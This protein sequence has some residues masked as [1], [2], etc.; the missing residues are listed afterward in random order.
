MN[1]VTLS[2]VALAA[3][4]APVQI[5]AAGLTDEQK[6]ANEASYAKISQAISDAIVY[7]TNNCP[8]VK[9]GFLTELSK[10][11]AE[12]NKIDR[13]TTLINEKDFLARVDEQK[14]GAGAA[15]QPHTLK[16]ILVSK[17]NLLKEYRDAVK[18][19]IDGLTYTGKDKATKLEAV[20]V[21]ALVNRVDD[22]DL[23]DIN[24]CQATSEAITK[25]IEAANEAIKDIE[26]N[27]V[28]D[29]E[30]AAKEAKLQ[31]D[32]LAAK[33]AV[34]DAVA[35]ARTKYNTQVKNTISL[36]PTEPYGDWQAKALEELNAQNRIL[37]E[38]TAEVDVQ[39]DERQNVI[40]KK[41]ANLE[42]VSAVNAEI[43]KIYNNW[44][45]KKS[46]QEEAYKTKTASAA[47]FQTDLNTVVGK[48]AA[49]E[50]AELN[51]DI[52]AIQNK[53]NTLNADIEKAYKGH[54]IN[55][56]TV[57]AIGDDITALDEKAQPLISNYNAYQGHLSAIATVKGTFN[58]AKN[59]AKKASK[60]KK[61]KAYDYLTGY[62]EGIQQDID[63]LTTAAEA[64][65]K[66]KTSSSHTV[67][68]TAVDTKIANYNDWATNS[69]KSYNKA[70]DNIAK[71][72]KQLNELTAL[73]PEADRNVTVDGTTKGQ[74]YKA[75]FEKLQGEIKAINDAI[76]AAKAKTG[77]N[78]KKAMATAASKTYTTVEDGVK[79][80]TD[81]KTNFENATRI[82]A[83]TLMV[84]Q[85]ADLVTAL[86]KR[87]EKANTGDNLGNQKKVIEDQISALTTEIE[88]ANKV[89]TDAGT[90]TAENAAQIIADLSTVNKN[91]LDLEEKVEEVE[92]AAADARVNHSLYTAVIEKINKVTEKYEDLNV[93]LTREA[94]CY[95]QQM[96]EYA[97]TL[98]EAKTNADNAYAQVKMA[99]LSESINIALDN[100]STELDALP[101][102]ISANNTA[103]DKQI[104]ACEALQTLWDT[105][106]DK[107]SNYDLSSDATK[108]LNRLAVEQQNI[109]KLS[110]DIW[111][112]WNEGN[113]VAK[114]SEF[115]S[116]NS[117]IEKAIKAI[118]N[119]Q[120]EGYNAAIEAD[121][122]KQHELFTNGTDGT[123][124]IAYAEFSNAIAKL[125][126]FSS[127]KNDALKTAVD[128]LVDTHKAIYAYAEKL[129]N[130]AAEESEAYGKVTSP[131]RYFSKVYSDQAN[132]YK[133]EIAKLLLDYQTK[134]NAE[135][136]KIYEE[137]WTT[138]DAAVY[139][140]KDA[141]DAYEYPEKAN[142]FKDIDDVLKEIQTALDKNDA[143]FALKLDTWLETIALDAL[144]EQLA[145]DKEK[146][147]DAEYTY[148]VLKAS[149]VYQADKAAI[150]ALGADY[151]RYVDQLVARAEKTIDAAG[152]LYT[153]SGD[154]TFD[155]L[156]KILSKLNGFYGTAEKDHTDI[157]NTALAAKSDA[158]ANQ[159]AYDKLIKKLDLVEADFGDLAANIEKLLVFYQK[160]TVYKAA[161]D[162]DAMLE[163]MRG[164]VEEW[165]GNRLCDDNEADVN[166]FF[167]ND[168]EKGY[169]KQI[170]D[171][172]YLTVA[173]EATALKAEVDK[174][175]DLFNQ[176]AAQDLDKVKEYEKNINALSTAIDA[177]PT[178]YNESREDIF[179]GCVDRYLEIEKEIAEYGKALDE[180]ANYGAYAAAKAEVEAALPAVEALVAEAQEKAAYDEAIAA[181]YGDDAA[182]V[183]ESLEE[184]KATIAAADEAGQLL[185]VKDNLINRIGI[186]EETVN[187]F[188]PQLSTV[189]NKHVTSN[190]VYNSLSAQI[191]S[192]ESWFNEV[193]GNIAEYEYAA[194]YKMYGR[195]ANG[196]WV[197][198]S[199]VD[200]YNTN[201]AAEIEL[202]K[203]DLEAAKANF[204]LIYTTAEGTVNTRVANL[205]GTIDN[206][207]K[208]VTVNEAQ[209]GIN[210]V[211]NTNY[212]AWNV[213]RSGKY[214]PTTAAAIQAEYSRI[215]AAVNAARTYN[216]NVSQ[217]GSASKD[218]YGND[219]SYNGEPIHQNYISEAWPAVKAW[220]AEFSKD[221]EALK[222]LVE[223]NS[224]VLG[225]LNRDGKVNVTDY[226]EV[227]RIILS[228]ED[229]DTMA[230]EAMAYAA[231]VNEDGS[232]NVA[233]LSKISNY[234]FK[235]YAFEPVALSRRSSY[236]NN[237]V[238]VG[239]MTTSV[240]GEETTLF[241]KTVRIALC[242][243]STEELTAGQMDIV[244]PEG[245]KAV[246]VEASA[247]TANHNVALGQLAN[248]VRVLI[249]NVENIAISGAEGAVAYLDVQVESSY[250]GGD[251][252]VANILFT[253]SKARSLALTANGA[254]ATTGIDS[255]QA[256]TVKERIYSVGGQMKKAV[257]KGI[258]IIVGENGSV[259]KVLKK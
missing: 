203:N 221:V 103:K 87:L 217:Y 255:V 128:N 98:N 21:D 96:S 88:A 151:K 74:T 187:E 213:Y 73:V 65:Y 241:G 10:I 197:F 232:I 102:T 112:V 161:L 242:V 82:E 188:L 29:E 85:A 170:A 11:Q 66:E 41:D 9:D 68:S 44:A 209:Q 99:K 69:L 110:E 49:N 108:Y 160:G 122:V 54:T 220:V 222:A 30:A 139:M 83:A 104:A 237:S 132:T 251:I 196:N 171:L 159:A 152:V 79:N 75:L 94:I 57:P 106:F 84:T 121:N 93:T 32:Y 117:E 252:N 179:V 71:A 223:N 120:A 36:L 31:A 150:E 206:Y 76:T 166:K 158:E 186:V 53:I 191:Q 52:T 133:R 48:L 39:G 6:A 231:D 24:G 38:V 229:K 107:I 180:I 219:I 64:A 138:A 185:L 51:A 256:A 37:I 3:I 13:K 136:I 17:V 177:V 214:T 156:E 50:K 245:M 144:T 201:I 244:L 118:Q 78:H 7:V 226:D 193:K 95:R 124:E 205:R 114:T 183:A 62:E 119:E 168:N 162:V 202:T 101:A 140:A 212:T 254:G 189:Y 200:W 199:V 257:Q 72:Q 250:N 60:D 123:W 210:A 235:G 61:Y 127:I 253:D 192:A 129:R 198:V 145:A 92:Q 45:S 173:D 14:I 4:A 172:K 169:V 165:Y 184:V 126:A 153:N 258:N 259:K 89:I 181:L 175:K 1:K 207:Y 163:G 137:T 211:D 113:S 100:I 8:D 227:R 147:A 233:D 125:N 230:D 35:E 23:K 146:A 34:T 215:Y 33:K 116:E 234:I 204:S 246:G 182:A 141:I 16:N 26:D 46:V 109:T 42:K 40:D 216:D 164:D 22:F 218:V 63:A 154:N 91:L 58:N 224:Y 143:D 130:L 90:P 111:A 81:N 142:A 228:G 27:L 20:G 77:E 86:T 28:K 115:A 195:D 248:G 243:N 167:A 238:N 155:E 247:R 25:D 194:D 178:K 240:E 12:L 131:D 2:A 55:A 208:Q 236:L 97:T 56:L 80:F 18:I 67:V 19:K 149:K 59:N 15:Q 157:Y 105:V 190:E 148:Q 5:Q 70:A 174:L 249:S 225:D 134:V 239:E 135:A 176:A 43:D 47:Q